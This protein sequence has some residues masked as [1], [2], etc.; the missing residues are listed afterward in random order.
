MRI[1]LYTDSTL[2]KIGEQEIAV[3]ALAREFALRG[4]QP[5]VLAPWPRGFSFGGSVTPYPVM[6]HPRFLSIDMFVSWY[7]RFLI[8]HHARYPFDVLHCHGLYPAAF[9]AAQA[10]DRLGVPLVVTCRAIKAPAGS[11][12][13]Q[14]VEALQAADS[15]IAVSG[16][17]RHMVTGLLPA[18]AERLIEMGDGIHLADFAPMSDESAV[19]EAMSLKPGAFALYLGRLKRRN[20]VDCL[21]RAFASLP[22]TITAQLVIAGE[23]GE[24]AGLEILADQ[25]DIRDRVRFLGAVSTDTARRLLRSARCGIVP[26][27]SDDASTIGVLEGFASGLPMIATDLADLRRLV[28]HEVNGLLVAP[29][30][31]HEL[32]AAIARLFSDDALA[33]RLRNAASRAVKLHDWGVI[34]ERHLSLYASLLKSRRHLIAA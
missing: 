10:K 30:A 13:P 17:V 6:W 27:R 11:G 26:S 32:A 33:T 20:G 34:A 12:T 7:Q 23:G 9:L 8:K 25:L 1:C 18:V 15:V 21:L 19:C 28:Q 16:S 31:P 4:H 2:P 14:V 22:A 24:R 5:T 3:D 29:D